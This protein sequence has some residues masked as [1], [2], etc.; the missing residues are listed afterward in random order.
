MLYPAELRDRIERMILPDLL[1]LSIPK[2]E[3]LGGGG[4]AREAGEVRG[5]S[6]HEGPGS[7]QL[8]AQHQGEVREAGMPFQDGFAAEPGGLAPGCDQ[9]THTQFLGAHGQPPPGD[10]RQVGG[11]PAG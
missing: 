5:Q 3:G 10:G 9:G 11:R 8:A 1:G 7:G 4:Q 2:A 6:V